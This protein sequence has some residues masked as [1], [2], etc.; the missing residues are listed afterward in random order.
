[1]ARAQA[2]EYAGGNTWAIGLE[3]RGHSRHFDPNDRKAQL[4]PIIGAKRLAN[5]RNN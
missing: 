3:I 1:M 5:L 4:L 2:G